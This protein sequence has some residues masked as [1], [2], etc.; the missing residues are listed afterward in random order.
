MVVGVT[1]DGRFSFFFRR[2]INT[3]TP[4]EIVIITIIGIKIARI[5]VVFEYADGFGAINYKLKV[6]FH[7]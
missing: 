1:T 2:K 6:E 5:K 4:I 7:F 3:I